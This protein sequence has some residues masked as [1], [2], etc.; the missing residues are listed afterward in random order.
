MK[1]LS[2]LEMKSFL[3]KEEQENWNIMIV[4]DEESIQK[5]LSRILKMNG[6]ECER[7][8][9]AEEARQLLKQKAYDLIL[10]DVNMPGENGVDFAKYVL[11]EYPNLAIIMVTAID[12]QDIVRA[13]LEV[14]A[15]GYIVKP[16]KPNEV[17]INVCNALHRRNLEIQN[18]FHRENLEK[19]VM[20][21]TIKLRETMDDL[22]GT[23]EGVIEAIGYTLEVKDSYTAGHQQRV[24][25]IACDIAKEIGLSEDQIE[26][27]RIAGAMHDIGKIAVSSQIL[28]KP[29]KLT[30]EEYDMIKTHP[31]VGHDI[32]KKINFPWP[33][34]DIIHQHHER[35]DGSG[36]P[37][38]LAGKAILIEARIVAVADVVEAMAS[39]RPYRPALGIDEALAEISVNSPRLY[40]ARVAEACIKLGTTPKLKQ[41]MLVKTNDEYGD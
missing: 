12:E 3:N 19:M 23:L 35:M 37:Q 20:E 34:A 17:I 4:D 14:G 40:D 2:L 33:L 27:V 11:T 41:E 36:Y 24:S 10:C 25:H 15:Y 1:S 6:N 32:L 26:S 7:A 28:N 38:G 13:A 30:Q 8:G 31:K 5:L 9:S 16:F 39:K 22:K 29:G 18:M 21:R